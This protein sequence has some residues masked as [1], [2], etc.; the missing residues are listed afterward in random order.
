ML[1]N[2]R[3]KI[4]SVIQ[5]IDIPSIQENLVTSI[6][7]AQ[8]PSI[9]GAS[10]PS[11]FIYQKEDVF[12]NP[13]A[14]HVQNSPSR[15]P[16]TVNLQAGFQQLDRNQEIWHSIRCL[17]EKNANMATELDQR[18]IDARATAE[19][20][21]TSIQDLN[22]TLA[23]L[24]TIVAQLKTCTETIEEVSSSMTEVE[25]KL[26]QLEDLV[27]VLNLQERQLDRRFEMAMYKEKKMA[28]LDKA[29]ERMAKEHAENVGRHEK[30]MMRIQQERQSVFQD[31]FQ[32]ELR[33]YKETGSIPSEWV[34]YSRF[35]LVDL[36][37]A[38][39]FAEV[40]SKSPP[41]QSLTLED[42]VL[43]DAVDGVEDLDDFL[44]K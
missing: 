7:N 21:L 6:K 29:R 15:V 38:L 16:R 5:N 28:E 12:S 23:I 42:V 31:A 44:G 26:M 4:N 11:S 30:G 22:V 3:K 41:S 32:D 33:H 19:K 10:V 36:I 9:F 35:K 13:S 39:S 27:E 20:R 14:R 1:E 17:N 24:P 34:E 2:F 25:S 8:T 37:G 40:V 18:I 43:D